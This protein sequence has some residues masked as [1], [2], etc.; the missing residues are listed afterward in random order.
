MLYL[1]AGDLA[2]D[3]GAGA[4]LGVKLFAREGRKFRREGDC[5]KISATGTEEARDFILAHPD[6]TSD[7]EVVKGDMDDV[8]LNVTG[9]SLTEGGE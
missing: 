2:A 5:Y 7:F 6:I 8:F 4:E 9:H 1:A 3:G